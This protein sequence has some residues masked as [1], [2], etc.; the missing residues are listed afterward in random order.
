[1]GIQWSSNNGNQCRP[2]DLLKVI[3][4]MDL[5]ELKAA[6]RLIKKALAVIRD[7]MNEELRNKKS[8][9][10][11]IMHNRIANTLMKYKNHED[12][13]LK[14][15]CTELFPNF[16]K[17]RDWASGMWD[18]V[19]EEI[20]AKFFPIELWSWK[21]SAD[22]I[23]QQWFKQH[24]IYTVPEEIVNGVRDVLKVCVLDCFHRLST[25][26]GGVDIF[27][28]NREGDTAIIALIKTCENYH[29][30]EI[31]KEL[32]EE[33]RKL[34]ERRPS[35]SG[36]TS[37]TERLAWNP[38]SPMSPNSRRRLTVD[39]K[40]A[41]T[42]MVGMPEQLVR[43]TRE[44]TDWKRACIHLVQILS[45][46]GAVENP[47]LDDDATCSFGWSSLVWA[48]ATGQAEMLQIL[49]DTTAE[50][51]Y[52]DQYGRTG[53]YFAAGAG[54][55]EIVQILLDNGA[56]RDLMSSFFEKPIDRAAKMGKEE[57]VEMLGG[58]ALV[59]LERGKRE[60]KCFSPMSQAQMRAKAKKAAQPQISSAPMVRTE[61]KSRSSNPACKK[62]LDFSDP[63][64][65]KRGSLA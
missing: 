11:D 27:K 63:A 44:A 34:K 14:K 60:F 43:L 32:A 5:K 46:A 65:L 21:D 29:K 36:S 2:D 58:K 19:I 45:Q 52:Q 23:V 41:E 37:P 33:E 31:Y 38:M 7:A 22:P 17:A 47:R 16:L 15:T 30:E 40:R 42:E 25:E 18:L 51:N 56:D 10:R 1:M 62:Q 26:L 20:C 49:L 48:C 53:L 13:Y 24:E 59:D 54:E 6:T 28:F 35:K 9:M 64:A 3:A 50:V 39:L 57:V 55:V 4:E 12:K 61:S 8:P